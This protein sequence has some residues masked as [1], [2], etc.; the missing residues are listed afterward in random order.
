MHVTHILSLLITIF[1]KENKVC[2]VIEFNF[3]VHN[4][5]RVGFKST[6][7][8]SINKKNELNTACHENLSFEQ[9]KRQ[10]LHGGGFFPLNFQS[11]T[12][13]LVE[14]PI[15]PQTDHTRQLFVDHD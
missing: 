1:F 2:V 10:F 15:N 12:C 6:V 13:G 7:I 9:V 11:F 5:V 8:F 14:R 3:F 4:C